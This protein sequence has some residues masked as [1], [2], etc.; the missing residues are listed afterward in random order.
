MTGLPNLT[1][2]RLY[3]ARIAYIKGG[4]D[5]VQHCMDTDTNAECVVGYSDAT[6]AIVF[7]VD[8]PQ[9][10]VSTGNHKGRFIPLTQ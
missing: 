2:A 7:Y 3:A 4:T 5:V 6:C 10:Q 8:D 1:I 9:C